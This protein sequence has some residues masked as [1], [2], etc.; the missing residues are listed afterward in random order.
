VLSIAWSTLRVRWVAFVGTLAA[1]TLGV[2]IIAS[3][4]IV[5]VAAGDNP[6]LEP[7]RYAAV[8]V[9]VRA[10]PTL[11]VRNRYGE[12]TRSRWPSSPLCSRP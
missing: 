5:L 9:V 6:H 7:L 4:G 10:D 2:S 8:P 11:R 12:P 3:M 1:L